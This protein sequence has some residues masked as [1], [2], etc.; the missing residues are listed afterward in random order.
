MMSI[1]E[2]EQQ[3]FKLTN[4]YSEHTS[5][6]TNNKFWQDKATKTVSYKPPFNMEKKAQLE[7]C[8][9][10]L[11]DELG[12]KGVK[13]ESKDGLPWE[14]PN[15]TPDMSGDVGDTPSFDFGQ[16]AFT[17]TAKYDEAMGFV[18]RKMAE[19]NTHWRTGIEMK[20]P[21]K[22]KSALQLNQ[23]LAAMGITVLGHKSDADHAFPPFGTPQGKPKQ[24]SVEVTFADD[25]NLFQAS[26]SIETKK[27]MVVWSG[28]R[29]TFDH[30]VKTMVLFFG[31]P[32]IIEGSSPAARSVK[33][34]P[35]QAMDPISLWRA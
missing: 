9:K 18:N 35:K 23:T 19:L 7:K 22:M 31:R 32:T 34:P 24:P 16:A 21:T 4:G 25:P 33:N 29:G 6:S 8:L 30:F 26:V 1:S 2:T 15:G 10:S 14:P 11:R 20:F 3:L 17:T 28:K 12:I 13:D 27:K 5:K